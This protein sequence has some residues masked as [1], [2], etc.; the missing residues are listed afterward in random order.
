MRNHKRLYLLIICISLVAN[1]P[2]FAIDDHCRLSQE[3][4]KRIDKIKS[5]LLKRIALRADNGSVEE[6][7]ESYCLI[8]NRWVRENYLQ[9]L[10]ELKLSDVPAFLAETIVLIKEYDFDIKSVLKPLIEKTTYLLVNNEISFQNSILEIKNLAEDPPEPQPVQ[11]QIPQV[12]ESAI[13]KVQKMDYQGALIDFDQAIPAWEE[14]KKRLLSIDPAPENLAGLIKICETSITGCYELKGV[15]NY[16]IGNLAAAFDCFNMAVTRHEQ[17]LSP[18][19]DSFAARREKIRLIML[20]KKDYERAHGLARSLHGE[21]FVEDIPLCYRVYTAVLLFEAKNF[22]SRFQEVIDLEAEMRGFIQPENFEFA[23]EDS[24]YRGI[25]DYH[26]GVAYDNLNKFALADVKYNEAKQHFDATN[27]TQ[28]SNQPGSR[29]LFNLYKGWHILRSQIRF[30]SS[31]APLFFPNFGRYYDV[32]YIF[33]LNNVR[34]IRGAKLEFQLMFEAY[35]IT[36]DVLSKPVTKIFETQ[37]PLVY[38]DEIQHF[39]G[40]VKQLLER[41]LN[42]GNMKLE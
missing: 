29:E 28:I 32:A 42:L 35:S 24:L 11:I 30:H 25:Y 1:L 14:E 15:C 33:N 7:L 18:F 34:S 8:S 37:L 19:P 4:S 16:G 12:Y 6:M 26:V 2:V 39:F 23:G 13:D 20:Y 10:H 41:L 17:F 3:L 31:A 40:M 9:T 36:P 5:H 27:G 38:S 22:L 21:T